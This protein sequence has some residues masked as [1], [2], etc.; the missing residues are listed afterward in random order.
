MRTETRART[1]IKTISW[2]V[3]ATL[4]TIAIVLAITGRINVALQIGV[5]EVFMKILVY[6][7]HERVWTN[8]TFGIKE[9]P[10]LVLWFTGLSGCG[11]SQLSQ[12]IYEKLQRKKIRAE[13]FDGRKIREIFPEIGYAPN[14]R[15]EH[16]KQIGSLVKI[17]ENN[18]T[19]VVG[20]FESPYEESRAYLRN[21]LKNYI[22]IY[23]YATLDYCIKNDTRGLYRKALSGE[24][25]NFVGVSIKYEEPKNPNIKID[26]EH[27]T[28]EDSTNQIITYLEKNNYLE[29]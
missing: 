17:L 4:T 9:K 5:I 7:L 23:V 14:K 26:F 28:V 16:I 12:A 3:T 25:D 29:A 10:P 2:R 27:Q 22:E 8:M 13:Y 6:Y 11:K 24:L 1:I 20:S 15:K 21:N 19:T 18:Y